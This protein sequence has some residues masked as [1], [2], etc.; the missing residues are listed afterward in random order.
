MQEQ[1]QG[2]KQISGWI[3][4]IFFIFLGLVGLFVWRVFYFTR[5]LQTGQITDMDFS[6]SKQLSIDQRLFDSF[7]NTSE[8]Q[9][10]S[11][12]DDPQMGKEGAPLTLVVFADFGCPYSREASFV[13]RSLV[14]EHQEKIQYIYRDFPLD[15]LHP[16]ARLAAEAA[17]CAY[18]Q[19]KFW[20][21]HDKIYQNQSDLSQNRFLS[22]AAALDLNM[23]QFTSCLQERVHQQ[24]IQED[25]E[26]GQAAGVYGTPTFFFNGFRVPGSIPADTFRTLVE[27]FLKEQESVSTS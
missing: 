6:F 17:T 18:D 21:F 12:K 13:T 19:G 7:S 8:I 2:K 1:E 23:N 20:E 4:L 25:I 27:Q 14:M 15:D 5:L 16:Q 24:E 11:T 26:D 22:Y 9:Q 10:V 3:I